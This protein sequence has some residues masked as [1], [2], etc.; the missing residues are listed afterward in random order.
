MKIKLSIVIALLNE[1]E[2]LEGIT[3]EVVSTVERIPELELE[4]IFVDDGSTDESWQIIRKLCRSDS[5]FRGL[6]LSR[7][8]GNHAALLSGL[9]VASGD[10]AMNLAADLQTPVD[11]IAPFYKEH[12]KGADVVFGAR[13]QRADT[14]VDLFCARVFYGMVNLLTT[15]RMPKGGIDVFMISRKV[16]NELIQ[17]H[18][19]NTSILGLIMNLGFEQ[20][21]LE[22]DRPARKQGRSKW[23]LLKKVKLFADGI[24][25]FSGLPLRVCFPTGVAA[26]LL[27]VI[28]VLVFW[29]RHP[30][31][32]SFGGAASF[33]LLMIGVQLVSV[34]LVGEYLYR[35]FQETSQH[36][37]FVVR[38]D[39]R[40][41]SKS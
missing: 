34:A 27:G 11:L 25:A 7:N 35:V 22:Y 33:V 4:L 30:G 26:F 21:M 37:V 13:R 40:E 12:Q 10:V 17:L 38:E 14:F 36:P 1:V 32:L 24:F 28:G 3:K 9:K 41:P 19:R 20:R 31:L 39:T 8:F 23:T 15:Q 18:G 6:R 5:R 2:G 29:L 16:I